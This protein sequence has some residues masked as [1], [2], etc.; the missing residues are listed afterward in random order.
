MI[1][2]MVDFPDISKSKDVEMDQ[3][4][5]FVGFTTVGFSDKRERMVPPEFG[6][7]MFHVTQDAFWHESEWEENGW[8]YQ[9]RVIDDGD[10]I[11]E[12]KFCIR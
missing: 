9:I 11:E 3:D 12:R 8:D 2:V 10:E 1:S 5:M 7:K 4:G 6:H